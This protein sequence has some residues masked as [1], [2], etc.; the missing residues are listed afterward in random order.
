MTVSIRASLIFSALAMAAL[1]AAF[2]A[3]AEKRGWILAHKSSIHS[4]RLLDFVVG[5]DLD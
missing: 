4:G 5:Y 1:T 2:A 3:P